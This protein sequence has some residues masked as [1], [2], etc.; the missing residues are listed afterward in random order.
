MIYLKFKVQILALVVWLSC[1]VQL[2]SVSKYHLTIVSLY[3]KTTDNILH[4]LSYALF[5][6]N[7]S[8]R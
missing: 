4:K 3:A 7:Y 2:S 8:S 1:F 5:K 6:V